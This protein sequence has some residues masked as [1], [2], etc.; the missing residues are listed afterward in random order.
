MA[1]RNYR[2]PVIWAENATTTIPPMPL[3][4]TA[5]RNTD[6]AQVETDVQKGWRYSTP[7]D[8]AKY[9]QSLFLWSS[10]LKEI[11]ERG[12]VPYSTE[13]DY[14]PGAIVMGSDNNLYYCISNNGPSSSV[15]DP[16]LLVAWRRI[17]FDN[18]LGS[19]TKN[20]LINGSFS[21]AQYN[22]IYSLADGNRDYTVFN[23]WYFMSNNNNIEVSADNFFPG[24]EL[25]MI[26]LSTSADSFFLVEQ[27]IPYDSFNGSI[28]DSIVSNQNNEYMI[29]LD[30][31]RDVE[32]EVTIEIVHLDDP[33]LFNG[34]QKSIL[35]RKI[36]IT[37]SGKYLISFKPPNVLI[38]VVLC[39]R[40]WFSAGSDFDS[41]TDS[42]GI[43]PNIGSFKLKHVKFYRV[44]PDITV[45]IDEEPP[46][47]AA[48]QCSA[49]L[50][51]SYRYINTKN[52]NP[53]VPLCITNSVIGSN[54]ILGTIPLDSQC[55]RFV[56]ARTQNLYRD[57]T[58][59]VYSLA[60]TVN[61]VTHLG[62]DHAVNYLDQNLAAN[63]SGTFYE[64]IPPVIEV[65]T[66]T[67]GEDVRYHFVAS[68]ETLPYTDL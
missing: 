20:I 23:R 54:K 45:Q 58:Y 60:G 14:T 52:P 24:A 13:V 37:T 53:F 41:H 43:Q 68:M 61:N 40:I 3:V 10:L 39:F 55:Y 6:F 26:N 30:I 48:L 1:N 56:A 33:E 31:I 15:S 38:S 7:E 17:F 5:Y 63:A 32:R 25:S 66:G 36:N 57:G 64:Y 51:T 11:D 18:P 44:G 2:V 16:T 29:E 12:V 22:S 59:T 4:G 42:L 35:V 27:K 67:S 49:F 9:N 34:T 65:P 62:V 28:N 47:Y 8:S 19:Y 50:Q 46:S 21:I